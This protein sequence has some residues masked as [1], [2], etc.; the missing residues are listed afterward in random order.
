[1]LKLPAT[2]SEIEAP[3]MPTSVVQRGAGVVAAASSAMAVVRGRLVIV[4]KTGGIHSFSLDDAQERLDQEE[5]SA[6]G[7]ADPEVAAAAAAATTSGEAGAV[8]RDLMYDA[9]ATRAPIDGVHVHRR[10]ALAATGGKE[11]DLQLWDLTPGCTRDEPLFSAK[12]VQDHVLGVRAP[13]YITG[14][15]IVDSHVVATL[16]AHR[17]VRF[18]DRRASERPVQ[19]FQIAREIDRRPTLLSQWNC[20]K[21]LVGEAGGDIHLYDTRRGFSSR[22]KLRGGNGSI[23]AFAKHPGGANGLLATTGLDRRARV[24]HVPTGRL[25][26]DMYLKQMGTAVLLSQG[27][28]LKAEMDAWAT[29]AN[30]KRPER[31]GVALGD[32]AWGE[33]EAAADEFEAEEG[34]ETEEAP[35]TTF[36]SASAAPAKAAGVKR[37]RSS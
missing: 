15:C 29:S 24:F 27:V 13:V 3:V 22:A 1:V 12:N 37:S 31:L 11:N 9:E 7:I 18:Y 28:P 2:I 16:T 14:C 5:G 19:D 32:A 23:R 17:Q 34:A 33:M 35:S 36:G 4:P 6:T 30:R 8:V 10:Y 26:V 21:F 25:L 20:N